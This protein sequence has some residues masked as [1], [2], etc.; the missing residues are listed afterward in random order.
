[1]NNNEL[2]ERMYASGDK[3]DFVHLH[4]HSDFSLKDGIGKP[5]QYVK[6]AIEIGMTSIAI[7]DHGSIGAHPSFFMFCRSND[8]K[9]IVGVE[10]Y[11]Q[12]RRKDVKR[13]EQEANII[14]INLKKLKQVSR[15]KKV[16]KQFIRNNLDFVRNMLDM[17]EANVEDIIELDFNEVKEIFNEKLHEV[18]I[19]KDR[20]T[21]DRESLKR[22]EH[23]V[24]LAKNEKGRKNITKIVSNAAREGFYYK[25]RTSFDY[26]C[27]N[28]EGIIIT[29]ACL[30]GPLHTAIRKAENKV[31]AKKKAIKVAKKYKEVF[32]DDFYIEIMPIDIDIQ[33]SGN[34]ILIEIAKEL[35][36]K[37]IITN[38][39]HYLNSNGVKA[40]E[41]SLMLGSKDDGQQVTMRDKKRM[42]AIKEIL[43]A[44]GSD[45]SQNHVRRV[46]ND[47]IELDRFEE[48]KPTAVKNKI[49]IT[50]EEIYLIITGKK[51]FKTV[52][53]FSTKDFWFK[54]RHELI[55]TYFEQ[56]HYKYIEPNDFI[57]A[58][59]NTLEVANKIDLWD[60]D[61][62][63]KLPQ[64]IIPNY[65][66]T[67][68][69]MVEMV[70]DGWSRKAE[71]DWYENDSIYSKRVK[72]ELSVI[73][74]LELADYFIIVAD[75]IKHAKNNNIVVGAGR[76]CFLPKINKVRMIDDSE[77]P[78]EQVNKGDRIANKF[79]GE[80]KV[81][82]CFVYNIDEDV[83][84]L[85]FEND[86]II[87]TLDHKF[88]TRNRDEVKAADLT[89]DDEVLYGFKD[90]NIYYENE[91]AYQNEIIRS[92]RFV[93]LKNRRIFHYTGKVYDIKV[94]T[95]DKS[96]IV[97][98][99][100]VHNSAA[101]S[102]VCYLLDITNIDP[103]KHDLLFERFLSMSRSMAIYDL[104]IPED[105]KESDDIKDLTIDDDDFEEWFDNRLLK[106]D[107]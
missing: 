11:M 37:C 86:I 89:E 63:E 33:K 77:K 98:D 43:I 66:S 45:I 1:M 100:V 96:Y 85:T 35:D 17:P 19:Q 70:R 53:E 78:I 16:N 26:L 99:I 87:C 84:E 40:Q 73:R 64:I 81:E 67:Y 25:P 62:K 103:I 61:T 92:S 50:F 48:F 44:I 56:E 41:V 22:N 34:K 83:I 42:H 75:Y 18:Q 32:G 105:A 104:S 6:R 82:K 69:Y 27:E 30:A 49:A 2:K 72:Y 88:F 12:N 47:F 94:S 68:D 59:D 23:I 65:D 106:M 31:E 90:K 95:P 91:I 102:L 29:S 55:D 97:N 7:T 52:W 28:K 54:D 46:Y 21:K 93:T 4:L 80:S 57:I 24:L 10:A 15:H 60:W 101:G 71:D 107:E 8:I 79:C 3:K 58:L 38:D 36:I 39:V 51:K 76:G 13:L 74:R 9:P 14:D 5:T 20:L